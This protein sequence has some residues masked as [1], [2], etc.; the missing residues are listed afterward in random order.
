MNNIFI[1][2]AIISLALFGAYKMFPQI[3]G[4]V[5]YYI[6]NPQFQSSIITPAV[7]L[8][9]K[10]LPEKI[11]IPTLKIMGVTT[12]YTESPLKS[13]TDEISQQAASVAASLVEKSSKAVSEQFCSVLLEK[14]KSECGK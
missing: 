2:L 8:A 12:E 6:K 10:A 14:I 7:N 4:P 1:R 11:Q 5:D 9:N 3:S 13:I